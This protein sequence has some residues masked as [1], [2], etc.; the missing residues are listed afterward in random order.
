MMICDVISKHVGAV[1]VFSVHNFGVNN[2]RL[3]RDKISA[4][5]GVQCSVNFQNA[6]CNNKDTKGSVNVAL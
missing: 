4:F 6:R 3:I 2:F 1:E 5:V